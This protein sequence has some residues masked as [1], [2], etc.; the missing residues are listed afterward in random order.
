MATTPRRV[1]HRDRWR[2]CGAGRAALP[3]ALRVA[4]L[5]VAG[6]RAGGF[7]VPV[8]AGAVRT[9]AA[10]AV[11]SASAWA[12]VSVRPSASACRSA[13][14]SRRA[15][16]SRAL[17]TGRP[18]VADRLPGREDVRE[19]VRDAGTAASPGG[20]V[21]VPGVLRPR[22]RTGAFDQVIDVP[23]GVAERVLTLSHPSG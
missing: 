3:R 8:P 15:C 2:S 11:R 12:G 20:L 23:R 6:L 18:P 9:A 17:I 19:G 1:D 14:A 22:V 16:A 5:R 7:R 10:A 4:G 21:I 13:M